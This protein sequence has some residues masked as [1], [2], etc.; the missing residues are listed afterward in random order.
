V[1]LTY[2]DAVPDIFLEED[3]ASDDNS[4]FNS[5]I[6]CHLVNQNSFRSTLILQPTVVMVTYYYQL[7]IRA[8]LFRDPYDHTSNGLTPEQQEEWI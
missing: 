2:R 7:L 1:N 5:L 4:I 3:K 8:S 6:V